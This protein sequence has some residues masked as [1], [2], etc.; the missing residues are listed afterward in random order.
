MFSKV[1]NFLNKNNSFFKRQFGFR[2][3]HS[4]VHA[5]IDITEEIRT[6]LDK[7]EFAMGLFLD[8]EFVVLQIIGLLLI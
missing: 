5:L 8:L 4:T 1:F 2:Q 6:A 3:K 7:N